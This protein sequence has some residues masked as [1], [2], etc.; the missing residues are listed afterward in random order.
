MATVKALPRNKFELTLDDGSII[1]GQYGTWSYDRFCKRRGIKLSEVQDALSDITNVSVI[2]D[3]ILSAV[4]KCHYQKADGTPFPYNDTHVCDW[5]DELGGFAS[6]GLA[7]LINP[8]GD[9]EEEK[10]SQPESQ[11]SGQS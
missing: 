5:I 9:T 3:F 10:K 7:T 8:A 1:Y 2:S 11:L 6:D 4:E